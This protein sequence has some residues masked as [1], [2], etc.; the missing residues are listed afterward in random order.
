MSND[1]IPIP[2]SEATRLSVIYQKDAILILGIDKKHACYHHTTYGIQPKDKI[3]I[4]AVSEKLNKALSDGAK[5]E[6]FEDFRHAP[7]AE[8]K[9]RIDDL[10]RR[11]HVPGMW[12]CP[13]CSFIQQN[14]YMRPDGST[15]ANTTPELR[16]CPNDGHDMI[17]VTWEEH[18]REA[19]GIWSKTNAELSAIKQAA[20]NLSRFIRESVAPH[21]AGEQQDDWPLKLV[22]T[23][24]NEAFR[25]KC[26]L[27]DQ[28][29]ALAALGVPV[30]TNPEAQ[31]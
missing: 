19:I 4:A 11:L 15:S 2:V 18:A 31:S 28:E 23:D 14:A 17:P 22:V 12:R 27:E 6:T 29:K 25:L 1:Y 26:F 7:A 13:K 16:P 5:L 8:S 9:A 10:E 20:Y 24:E 21:D 30:T 3:A